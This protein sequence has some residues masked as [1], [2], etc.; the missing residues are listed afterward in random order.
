MA[1]KTLRIF[2]AE[3]RCGMN[4]V[5]PSSQFYAGVACYKAAH[6]AEAVN[7]GNRGRRHASRVSPASAAGVRVGSLRRF[8]AL[9]SFGDATRILMQNN[10]M[11][12]RRNSFGL[13]AD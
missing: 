6:G 8:G 13:P 4:G 12:E 7:I 3:I 9:C 11:S 5:S 10:N 1:L 2:G